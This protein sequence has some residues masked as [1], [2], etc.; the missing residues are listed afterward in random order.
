M[1]KEIERLTLALLRNGAGVAV[2]LSRLHRALVADAG[3]GVGSPGQ[4]RERLR[5]RPDLFRLIEPAAPW[6]VAPW[7]ERARFEYEPALREV[8]LVAEPTV[9]LATAAPATEPA[10]DLEAFI[11]RLDATL[12]DLCGAGDDPERRASYAEAASQ[13]QGL[14]EAVVRATDG[15]G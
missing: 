12:A 5:R 15:A 1:Q 3:P 11:L 4:L 6:E 10:T 14:R 2:P 8:G 13:L 9:V 7:S